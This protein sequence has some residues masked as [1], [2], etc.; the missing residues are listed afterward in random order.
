MVAAEDITPDLARPLHP[1]MLLLERIGQNL[2]DLAICT[3]EVAQ[4]ANVMQGA[5]ESVQEAI[6]QTQEGRDSSIEE[7]LTTPALTSYELYDEGRRTVSFIQRSLVRINSMVQ[8]YQDAANAQVIIAQRLHDLLVEHH[9]EARRTVV[10]MESA[11]DLAMHSRTARGQ[12]A[13][14]TEALSLRTTASTRRH[15]NNGVPPR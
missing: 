7:I 2:D 4:S 9:N 5:L 15:V 8:D 13:D 10:V 11:L 3:F 1:A 12:H 14:T 6:D